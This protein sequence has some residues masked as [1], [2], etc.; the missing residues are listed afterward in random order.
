MITVVAFHVKKITKP[1]TIN[2][3]IVGRCKFVFASCL[4]LRRAKTNLI[5]LPHKLQ[6]IAKKTSKLFLNMLELVSN[7]SQ[8]LSLS[9][10]I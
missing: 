1:K 7:D 3:D 9:C 2:K 8:Q 10:Q 5:H 6:L 4:A